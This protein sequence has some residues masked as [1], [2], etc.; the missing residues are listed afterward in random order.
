MAIQVQ[1][2]ATL[3]K[4]TRSRQA[5]T[6]VPWVP[7]LTPKQVLLDE[8]FSEADAE[9][10]LP[11]IG[12]EQVELTTALTDGT[13]LEFIVSISGGNGTGV[14]VTAVTHPGQS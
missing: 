8:G 4:R 7:G 10:I 2:F 14:T 5:T 11:V 12:G 9:A 6:A 3:V 1:W 13:R